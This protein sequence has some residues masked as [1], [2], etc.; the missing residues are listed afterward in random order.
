[1]LWP[2]VQGQLPVISPIHHE[3]PKMPP[4]LEEAWSQNGSAEDFHGSL[5]SSEQSAEYLI[6]VPGVLCVSGN[7]PDLPILSKVSSG[8]MG[9][10]LS[11][12]TP[13]PLVHPWVK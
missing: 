6:S 12:G 7:C 9:S 11:I 5:L 8:T 2:F 13:D 10:F 4:H 1:M 3:R